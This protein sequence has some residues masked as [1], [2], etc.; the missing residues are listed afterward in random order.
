MIASPVVGVLALSDLATTTIAT[1]MALCVGATCIAQA[2]LALFGLS[3]CSLLD[4]AQASR[5]IHA[6]AN[7]DKLE[8]PAP[9][10]APLSAVSAEGQGSTSV[11]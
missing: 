3:Y 6:R 2:P 8:A 4:W 11:N 9:L 1:K 10:V 5:V 7:T